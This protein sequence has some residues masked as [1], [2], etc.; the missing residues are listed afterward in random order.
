MEDEYDFRF[1]Q[2]LFWYFLAVCFSVLTFL[3]SNDIQKTNRSFIDR[4]YVQCQTVNGSTLNG[5]RWAKECRSVL[6]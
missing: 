2:L 3:I 5:L 4:G 6:P 1:M